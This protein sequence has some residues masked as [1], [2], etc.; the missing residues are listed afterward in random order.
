MQFVHYIALHY[1]SYIFIYLICQFFVA[2]LTKRHWMW[3]FPLGM[4]I[5]S[6]LQHNKSCGEELFLVNL[7][8]VLPSL[9]SFILGYNQQWNMCWS[10]ALQA[11]EDPHHEHKITRES[12]RARGNGVG[13]FLATTQP[14]PFV[15]PVEQ[16]ENG[17]LMWLLRNKWIKRRNFFPVT[18]SPSVFCCSSYHL[19]FNLVFI[20]ERVQI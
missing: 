10:V 12:Q 14:M 16:Q 9:M 3:D 13:V 8:I 17:S 5:K 7:T 4:Y 20:W 15:F 2:S 19:T 1:I 6:Q 18:A 11:S